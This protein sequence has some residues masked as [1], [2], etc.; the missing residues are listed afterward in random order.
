MEPVEDPRNVVDLAFSLTG[1]RNGGPPVTLPADHAY[2]L[3]AAVCR[4]LPWV[5]GSPVVGIHPVRGRL[6]GER[7]LVLTPRSVLAFRVPA[8]LIAGLLPLAGQ[9]L[10]LD[11]T[12]LRVGVPSMRALRPAPRLRSRL[13]VITGMLAPEAFLGAA[14]RQLDRLGIA[15]EPRLIRRS[16]AA[17]FEPD[18]AG[19]R[20][21]WV[22]R[23]LR[24]RDRTVVGYA[25]EVTGLSPADSVALQA[26]GLGGRRR[27]GCG[28]FTPMP[29]G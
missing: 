10:D 1:W 29:G 11:G 16:G 22:R 28:I 3:F 13:V 17:P 2:A 24:V 15:A 8:A 5:H 20:D 6:V 7:R 27:F 9:V 18:G 23:T 12:V 14:R 4:H 21:P 26:S 19:S 25:L